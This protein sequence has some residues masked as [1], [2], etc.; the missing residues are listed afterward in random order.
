MAGEALNLLGSIEATDTELLLN[1]ADLKA[2]SNLSLY[3]AYKNR[4]AI[5]LKQDNK[6]EARNAI[7]KAYCFWINYTSISPMT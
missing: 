3:N 1:I 6:A 7:A 5:F 4:A 2:M